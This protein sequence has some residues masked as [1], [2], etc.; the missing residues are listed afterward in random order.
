MTDSEREKLIK[1]DGKTITTESITQFPY[2][3]FDVAVDEK[4]QADDIVEIVWNGSSLAGRKV[5]MYAWNV[6][7]SKWEA[8]ISTIA[9]EEEFELIGKVTA[10]DYMK[11][12]NISVIVQD[13]IAKDRVDDTDGATDIADSEVSRDS[14][15][16]VAEE[17][18]TIKS[19]DTDNSGDYRD[20][21][22]LPVKDGQFSFVWFSDTQYYSESYPHIFENQVNWI[23]DA[24]EG[25]NLKYVFHT[26]DLV[27]KHYDPKQWEVADS[28][29]KIL[30]DANIPYG[31]LA[32]NHDVG[33]KGN[34]Y[35]NYYQYF[36][37]DRYND[38]DYFGESYLN[39]RGHYDLISAEG[40]DFIMVY[41]GW[42]V[43]QDGIDWMNEVLEK[44]P[45]RKA[46]LNFHEYLLAS[47]SRSPIGDKIFEEVVVPNENVH[48]VLG[49][50]YHNSQKLED[51]IDDDGDGKPD[52]TVYQMLANYQ[53]GPE[54]GQGFL[55]ILTFD[56]ETNTMDMTAYSPYLNEEDYYDP[57]LYPG[58]D[59]FVVDWDLT[60]QE[61]K[62]R[63]RLY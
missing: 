59:S 61:K 26:G 34:D 14:S 56:P 20:V 25:L 8:L 33:H 60:P 63:N 52:R 11:D 7:T 41:M 38:R 32:G 29:M 35:E 2:H 50:H 24:A 62:S 40:N 37:E 44:Y 22:D 21:L 15:H 48:A 55:R 45:N 4:V 3:R 57:E 5:T 1:K 43:D 54:G 27:D 28:N 58:K 31:V 16:P 9:G 53:A 39:N 13:E 51:R 30:D 23:V 10:G 18:Q 47:G 19:D 49:G 42:G 6:K 46:V 36:G 17:L 12:R